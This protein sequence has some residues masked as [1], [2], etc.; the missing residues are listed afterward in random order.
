MLLNNKKCSIWLLFYQLLTPLLFYLVSLVQ[1]AKGLEVRL[2]QEKEARLEL[3]VLEKDRRR[4]A[5]F[6]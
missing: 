6:F 2:E 1:Q 3:A 5:G 4:L